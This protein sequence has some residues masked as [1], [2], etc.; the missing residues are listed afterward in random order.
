MKTLFAL[1][2]FFLSGTLS[3]QTLQVGSKQFTESAILAEVI[4]AQLEDAGVAVTHRAGLGGTRILWESLLNGEIDIYPEYTGTLIQEILAQEK[5]TD[6]N[7]LRSSLLKRGVEMTETLGFSDTYAI[8]M[9]RDAA[10]RLGIESLSD[11]AKHPEIKIGVSNEFRDRKDGWPGLRS[12][13][14]L[15]QD[16]QGLDHDIAYRALREGEIGATDIYSTDAEIKQYDLQVLRDDLHYF[17]RYDAVILYRKEISPRAAEG[18]HSL[19]NQISESEMIALNAQVK[20]THVSERAAAE[21]FVHAKFGA[22]NSQ[23]LTFEKTVFQNI[24]QRVSE[25]LRLVGISLLGA[26]LVSIPLGVFAAASP[27]AG[28][29]ILGLIGA[30]QTIPALALLVLLIA[31]LKALGLPGIGDT[32]AIFALFLYSLLPIVRNTHSGLTNILPS[33][34]ESADALALPYFFR[35]TRIELPL[36]SPSILAGIKTA[37][38]INVGFATLG[39][40]I[41]AGGLGQPIL[42]GIRLDDYHLILEG[43]IPA[44]VLA[45]FFQ[46]GFD[47]LEKS[48]IPRALR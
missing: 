8:G 2:C 15:T 34:R 38:V 45:W 32:P 13:Y 40:L 5:V 14:H 48:I 7:A 27:R 16:A 17:P 28:G 4:R 36:A 26:I 9:K 31:P 20:L 24:I 12:K 25:H 10:A 47:L 19:E 41:G 29:F 18:L 1:L 43:A 44:V 35:L 33:I 39:A 37:A 21:A 46:L 42:T 11:L 22:G 30:I 3:A 6:L 23:P